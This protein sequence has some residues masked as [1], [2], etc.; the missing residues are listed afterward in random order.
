MALSTIINPESLLAHLRAT[1]TKEMQEAAEPLVREAAE[2]IER[3]MRQRLAEMVVA[4]VRTDVD[5][6]NDGRN[7]MIR[8][9]QEKKP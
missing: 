7:L 6:F 8:I 5:V 4:M 9:Q 1:L 2:K 3:A